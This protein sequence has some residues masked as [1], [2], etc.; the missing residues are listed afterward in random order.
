MKYV[1]LIRVDEGTWDSFTE[2]Q[3][4]EWYGRY[5]SFMEEAGSKVVDGAELQPSST[6]TTVRVRGD[7][8]QVTDGPFAETREQ[9]GGYFVF[10][11]ESMDEAVELAAKIPGA[12]HGTIEVRAHHAGEAP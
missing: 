2:D 3:Q 1:A 8:T 10:D 6:A 12:L 4:Q 7:E 9:I 11:C 5:R